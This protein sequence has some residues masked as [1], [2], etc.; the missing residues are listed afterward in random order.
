LGIELAK[1][2]LTLPLQATLANLYSETVAFGKDILL[3][4][5]LIQVLVFAFKSAVSARPFLPLNQLNQQLAQSKDRTHYRLLKQR[6]WN[7]RRFGL[8]LGYL[9]GLAYILF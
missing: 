4:A 8:V 9:A 6:F 7:R 5:L 3:S 2:G 1:F